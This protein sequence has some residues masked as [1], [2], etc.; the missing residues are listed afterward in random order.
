MTINNNL[1]FNN[2]I[3]PTIYYTCDVFSKKIVQNIGIY[4]YTI[5]K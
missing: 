2:I 4:L 1:W 3:V 5:E